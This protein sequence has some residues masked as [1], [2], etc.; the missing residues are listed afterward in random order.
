MKFSSAQERYIITIQKNEKHHLIRGSFPFSVKKSPFYYGWVILVAG[1]LGVL[2]SIPGQ[3]MGVSVYTDHLIDNL[4]ISRIQISTAYMIGTLISSLLMTKAGL[5][6]DKYGARV[7]AS[8]SAFFLG[9]CLIILSKSVLITVFIHNLTSI[10]AVTVA[11]GLMVLGFFGIRFFGQGVLTLVSRGMVMRW[12][13][14][15]RGFA[16]ALMGI[17]TSFGF[18]YAPRILQALINFSS[19]EKSWVFIGLTLIFLVLPFIIFI[20]RDSPEECEMEME[21]GVH[22]KTGSRSSADKIKKSFTLK[23]AKKDPQ[24]WF[25]LSLLFYWA[26]YNTAFTFHITSIF[27]SRGKDT[28]EAVAI[29]LPISIIAVGA[30]F[31]GSWLSDIVRMKNIFYALIVATFIAALAIAMPYNNLAKVLLIAGMGIA[32]GLFGVLTSVT[33][34]KLYGRE[35]LGAISGLAMSFMV[36]GSAVGPWIFSIMENIWGHYRYT[37]YLGMAFTLIIGLSS[38]PVLLKSKS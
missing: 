27:A 35:H 8:G 36:A 9:L 32:G 6:Y 11:F 34:P 1:S 25:Y 14:V 28:V 19:W 16:A 31:L 30:R 21:E 3:T 7:A 5:F 38:L 15:H 24:L 29:F 2:F 20:F 12:F 23:E 18:S 4:K 22:I 37:G 33:W 10:P 26:L 17:F 13:E